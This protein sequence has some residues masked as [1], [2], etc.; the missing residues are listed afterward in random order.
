[1][2]NRDVSVNQTIRKLFLV[3][4]IIVL[5]IICFV[6]GI[7][8]FENRKAAASH[9][10]SGADTPEEAIEAFLEGI[11]ENNLDKCY[12]M[13][14]FDEKFKQAG[15]RHYAS[16]YSTIMSGTYGY[17]IPDD[18]EEY[19]VISEA[20]WKGIYAR[21]IRYFMYA[22]SM[23]DEEYTSMV[24]SAITYEEYDSRI[25]DFIDSV[26]PAIVKNMRILEIRQLPEFTSGNAKKSLSKT[27]TYCDNVRCYSVLMDFNDKLFMTDIE[28]ILYQ[29][30][31]YVSVL[32]G[33]GTYGS[34]AGLSP[35]Y[36]GQEVS[37]EEEYWNVMEK[38]EV[39][40]RD[41]GGF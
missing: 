18:Y 29:N 23:G 31:W 34:Y 15:Y 32:G 2:R 33:G 40:L 9:V 17:T 16:I 28:V 7:L 41:A 26:N 6:E 39:T 14:S 19:R 13:I 8:L 25:D 27:N 12:S 30:R 5:G 1:M 10:I 22:V 38:L 36:K 4:G 20:E 11:K 21:D 3:I 24:N 35:Y 37:N